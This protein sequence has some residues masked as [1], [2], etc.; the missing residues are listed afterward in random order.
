M[1]TTHD[2]LEFYIG[3]QWVIPGIAEDA[4]GNPLNLN[5]TTINWILEDMHGV[6]LDSAT[7]GNGIVIVNA[8]LGQFL[9]VRTTDITKRIP[10]G[11]CQDFC[12][13]VDPVNAAQT[14]WTGL[15]MVL[16]SPF[17]T[18][19]TAQYAY[20][21]LSGAGALSGHYQ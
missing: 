16:D 18:P 20:A 8:A 10:P 4:N 19:T 7:Y 17:I 5:T 11:R 13:S 14:Q 21:N 6:H 15:V 2:I 1:T 9:V 3:D 12:Q